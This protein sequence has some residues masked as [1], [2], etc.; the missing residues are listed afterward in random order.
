MVFM[1]ESRRKTFF[2]FLLSNVCVFLF[3][4][5][6]FFLYQQ[7]RYI[8]FQLTGIF[9]TLLGAV[10][11]LLF[12][13]RK[14]IPVRESQVSVCAEQTSGNRF[15]KL[16]KKIRGL[17]GKM[18]H[19]LAHFYN[20]I[21]SVLRL[22]MLFGVVIVGSIFF[23]RTVGRQSAAHKLTYWHILALAALFV[24]TIVIDK[25][26]KYFETEDPFYRKILLNC[27]S[28]FT[29]TKI[30]SGVTGIA[31]S[32]FMLGLYDLQTIVRYITIFLFYYVVA[33]VIISVLVHM[34]RK[35]L[36]EN[37]GIVI[38]LPFFNSDIKELSVLNF[39]EENTGITLRSLWSLKFIRKSV[40]VAFFAALALLWLSS[41]LVYVESYQEAAVYRFG[42]LQEETLKPGLHWTLPYPIEKTKVYDTDTI[43]KITIGYRSQENEDNLWTEAHGD[44]EYKLLLGSG[45]E[46][47]SIN[48]RVE[49]RI[50][51]LY[52]F[53]KHASQPERI[54]EAKAY[55]IAAHRTM[56]QDLTTLLTIDR[57]DFTQ[58]FKTELEAM[59]DQSNTGIEVV[60]IVMES[61]HPP[62]EVASVYQRLIGVRNEAE[63]IVLD[64]ESYAAV[65]IFRSQSFAKITVDDA[66]IDYHKR[67]SAAHTEVSEFMAAVEAYTEHPEAYKYYKYL[68][69]ICAT[70]ARTKLL[71]V[72]QDVD[73][74]RIQLIYGTFN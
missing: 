24:V 74:S 14:G 18:L 21:Q 6:F 58:S 11:F 45:N 67:I 32:V 53:L 55:E 60:N 29:V 4:G 73:S 44:T 23:T 50:D 8:S 2:V 66:L 34:I 15:V 38:L 56:H 70:Y 42:T 9:L 5:V 72:G 13:F 43:R 10:N 47:V 17:L 35:E 64:A 51:D 7:S 25:Y 31:V 1:S 36:S 40:P 62:V 41:G 28:F 30:L 16:I 48:L 19:G 3:A 54:L 37:P 49:Y 52:Q 68:N 46:L 22:V 69:A 71:L 26:L 12:I 33:M 39:L 63:K 20:K 27:R 61:I 59:V 65:S 57:A